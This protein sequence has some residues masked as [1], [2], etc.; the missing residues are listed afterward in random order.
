LAGGGCG[1]GGII[2]SVIEASEAMPLHLPLAGLLNYNC[3]I[4]LREYS[5]CFHVITQIPRAGPGRRSS[6]PMP[7]HLSGLTLITK[8]ATEWA[9]LF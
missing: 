5:I 6:K 1:R 3:Q 2:C 9:F 4:Q 7:C 8:M